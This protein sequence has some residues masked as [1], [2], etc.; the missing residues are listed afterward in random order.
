MLLQK[1]RQIHHFIVGD[2]EELNVAVR[3]LLDQFVEFGISLM[4]GPQ[5]VCH[6][7][8]TTGLPRSAVR[9]IV[10][11][12]SRVTATFAS[13]SPRRGRRLL[14]ALNHQLIPRRRHMSLFVCL[15]VDQEGLGSSKTSFT[16]VL[17]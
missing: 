12:S 2:S 14:T 16:C 10:L 15:T 1:R 7:L 13:R 11:L 9:S 5:K 17:D 6:Q 8:M 4:Q 3:V